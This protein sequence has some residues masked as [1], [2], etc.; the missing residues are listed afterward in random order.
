MTL[1][2]LK[3]FFAGKTG[4]AIT[5]FA[6]FVTAVRGIWVVEP[7]AR[8]S[9]YFANHT[10]NGDFVLIWT[11]LP[12]MIR[13]KTRPVAGQ[14]YWLRTRLTKFIGCDV[15][16]AVLINRTREEGAPDPITQM[17]DAIDEG[18]SLILFPEGTRNLTDAPLLPFK[19]GLYN[20]ALARPDV[21]LVPVWIE[22]LN[23]VMPKG[24]IIPIPLICT[25]CFG[26][27]L[28]VKKNESKDAFLKRT[29][30]ALLALSIGDLA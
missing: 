15:F 22:N 19:A 3:P 29:S 27:A 12:P 25:V 16:N 8:Q 30:K 5:L 2:I 14:D 21:D 4:Q 9:V 20:L 18:A 24:E 6:R 7:S 10:S 13:R 17:T 26:A 28:H 23:S 1:S 11:V